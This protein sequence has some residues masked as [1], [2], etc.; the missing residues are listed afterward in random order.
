MK[1]PIK[2]MRNPISVAV[3]IALLTAAPA[4]V[5]LAQDE[6]SELYIDEILVTA[7]KRSETV[8]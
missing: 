1:K 6:S 4:T 2:R 7:R 5:T 3:Q 8:I